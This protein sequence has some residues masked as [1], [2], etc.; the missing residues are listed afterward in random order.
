LFLAADGNLLISLARSSNRLSVVA[1]GIRLWRFIH[2]MFTVHRSHNFPPAARSKPR[3]NI[4]SLPSRRSACGV[5]GRGSG[6]K[7]S[8]P[9]P[10]PPEAD[11]RQGEGTKSI[12][13]WTFAMHGRKIAGGIEA[14]MNR[15][16]VDG[17][18]S[19]AFMTH[20]P[21]V[22]GPGAVFRKRFFGFPAL[23]SI[24][25]IHRSPGR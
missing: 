7:A 3:A 18:G 25:P 17:A 22:A 2:R 23:L 10:I 21:Q 12:S 16:A 9:S 15:Q 6:R 20:H 1:H 19:T 8:E 5:R 13:G 24:A 11:L 4:N 14:P